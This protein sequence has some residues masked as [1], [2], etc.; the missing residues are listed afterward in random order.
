MFR[1][2]P[3]FYHYVCIHGATTKWRVTA[4]N[5]RLCLQCISDMRSTL[6]GDTPFLSDPPR[7]QLQM[8][9]LFFPRTSR[10]RK[11]AAIVSSRHIFLRGKGC[12]MSNE[13]RESN[14]QDQEKRHDWLTY[15]TA[16]KVLAQ[17]RRDLM[18]FL[19][20]SRPSPAGV[21]EP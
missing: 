19:P 10:F 6:A 1:S 21:T 20:P 12:V 16:R 17:P 7:S 8:R 13:E 9:S 3:Y 4:K 5:T 11:R 14:D 2:S 18:R 15:E